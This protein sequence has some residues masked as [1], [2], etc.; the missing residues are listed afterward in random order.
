MIVRLTGHM[1]LVVSQSK[2]KTSDKHAGVIC[3]QIWWCLQ[4]QLYDMMLILPAGGATVLVP[5]LQNGEK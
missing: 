4:R 2:H 3:M 5:T 1:G